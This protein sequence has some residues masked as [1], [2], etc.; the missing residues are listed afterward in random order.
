MKPRYLGFRAFYILQSKLSILKI[1]FRVNPPTINFISK[2]EW[3]DLN[4]PFFCPD[5][6]EKIFE[7]NLDNLKSRAK[8]T[9][10]H[11]FIFFNSV[12]F[13]LGKSYNWIVNPETGYKYDINQH[14][15][16]IIDISKEAGDIK[17]VWEKARFTF[18]YD[19]IRYDYHFKSDNSEFIFGQIE[20]FIDLNPINLGPNY[21]C[22]Q[23]IS[24]RILNW[25]YALFYYKNSPI[26]TNKLLKKIINSIYW[27]LNHI[28]KNINFSRIA[29]RNNHAIT[30][31]AMLY[32]SK[33]LFP[34][35]HETST[36]SKKGEKWLLQE[37]RYQIY[38]DGS[39]LQFSHNYHRVVIQTLSWVLRIN[40]LHNVSFPD[41]IMEKLE[42]TLDF[43][44]QHQ[45]FNT[46]WLPNYGNNDGALFFPLNSN[47]FRDFKPQLQ[48]FAIL[49]KK[50][51]LY[52][53]LYEDV[54]WFGLSKQ[55]HIPH[56][57]KI[58]NT[59]KYD[60]GGF[61]GFRD[62]TLTTI[63]CGKYK[64]RPFQADA[65]NID[66]WYKGINVLFDPGTYKYNTEQKYLNFYNGTKG[67]YTLT[68]GEYDQMLK[69][70]RFIWF[71]WTKNT[72]SKVNEFDDRFEFEG[73]I[74][75]FPLNSRKIKH[76]RKVIKF[77]EKTIWKVIDQTNYS[78]KEKVFIHWNINSLIE[79]NVS[80]IAIDNY[81]N[82]LKQITSN[83]WNSEMYGV[84]ERFTQKIYNIPQGY[85]ETTIEIRE[86]N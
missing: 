30:E 71:F 3:I 31:T 25:T 35:I 72:K 66:I 67:H 57:L 40:Q 19:L 22:S 75:G 24:L 29:V 63:R 21:K 34:F 70:E 61:Y 10:N 68:I 60:T 81:G 73:E 16:K 17:Y 85:C 5:S 38:D 6:N 43:L 8:K 13:K 74:E 33:Y 42:S 9:L 18:I 44:Y 55:N 39:Y 58:K 2:V 76:S 49:L 82:N 84:K 65:L 41:D 12:E 15:S 59:L 20:N 37:I 56:S 64:D 45:D 78:G 50:M 32:L 86:N 14:W 1:R 26:L 77:K 53:E 51:T 23:E 62:N 52:E 80:M 7:P 69:G 27:Q 4:I 48:V 47:H 46:G 83:G 11:T 54:F 79:K 28:Y 36:W